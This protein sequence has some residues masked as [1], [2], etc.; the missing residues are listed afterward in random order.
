[1]AEELEPLFSR[2]FDRESLVTLRREV[3][4]RSEEQG[5]AGLA[6]YRFVVAVNE[7]TT[8]AVRHGGGHGRLTLWKG[9]D[10]LFCEVADRGRGLPS[11]REWAPP[12]P[13]TSTT[14]RG[15][16]LARHGASRLSIRSDGDGT[17]V[18]LEITY[19]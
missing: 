19:S 17:S 6:L 15:L 2:D 13:A 14:G 4:R 10:R 7:I 12:P 9:D 1:M 5:L 16:L 8:N 11:G 3:E 18:L